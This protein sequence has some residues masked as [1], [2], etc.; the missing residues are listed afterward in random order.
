MS[1]FS[2]GM[3]LWTSQGLSLASYRQ[4]WDKDEEW[5]PMEKAGITMGVQGAVTRNYKMKCVWIV[6]TTFKLLV[7]CF[8]LDGLLAWVW[9]F[10]LHDRRGQSG[11]II[12]GCEPP[13]GYWEL[14]TRRASSGPNWP[15]KW[16]CA[17]LPLTEGT[18]QDFKKRS[19]ICEFQGLL[20]Q[21]WACIFTIWISL[22]YLKG[23]WL[24]AQII[25]RV[26]TW[27]FLSPI[28]RMWN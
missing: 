26:L 13:Y 18:G 11:P 15:C 5:G 21:K 20:W 12:D 10:C 25:L 27:E 24:D 19:F 14:S 6:W 9:V 17:W 22:H 8:H 28:N 16:R 23:G 1:K 3:V 4:F 2:L 7:A